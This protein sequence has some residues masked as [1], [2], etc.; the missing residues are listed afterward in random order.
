MTYAKAKSIDKKNLM[1]ELSG[2]FN[3]IQRKITVV[4]LLEDNRGIEEFYN[5]YLIR[6][7]AGKQLIIE[8]KKNKSTSFEYI[9]KIINKNIPEDSLIYPS[10][11]KSQFGS[12]GI[13]NR[14][15]SVP[16]NIPEHGSYSVLE[17]ILTSSI[18]APKMKW[19]Q[20]SYGFGEI[21]NNLCAYGLTDYPSGPRI[22]SV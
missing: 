10:R 2:Y 15:L 7:P 9:R 18:D 21:N 14:F 16:R 22:F 8:E 1:E 19:D 3:L 20:T 5:V 4:D 17:L 12:S 13:S 6:L 11:S